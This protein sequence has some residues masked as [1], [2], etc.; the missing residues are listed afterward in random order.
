MTRELCDRCE[1]MAMILSRYVAMR[2][3]G[4]DAQLRVSWITRSGVKEYRLSIRTRGD[5]IH[6]PQIRTEH[7]ET[8]G[9]V[10]NPHVAGP[11]EKLVYWRGSTTDL[12]TDL[13]ALGLSYEQ[14]TQVLEASRFW[15][16]A[17]EKAVASTKYASSGGTSSGGDGGSVLGR[18]ESQ[19][20]LAPVPLLLC[21]PSCNERHIDLGVWA[22]KPHHTHACQVCGHVWR[23]AIV[24]TVGVQFL[25]GFKNDPSPF[26]TL[27][28]NA[29][30]GKKL[31]ECPGCRS[32]ILDEQD[33][34]PGCRM[35]EVRP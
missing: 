14:W 20:V 7:S 12:A 32:L 11:G 30:Y 1:G 17:G 19:V 33:H 28:D 31:D 23:P 9:F 22:T 3:Q 25:P 6:A 27:E 18:S 4:E 5:E 2:Q 15:Q 13:D 16:L 21:C 34:L 8:F 35:A 10:L 29:Q 26:Q 24:H